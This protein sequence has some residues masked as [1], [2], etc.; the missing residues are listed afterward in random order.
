MRPGRALSSAAL[1]VAAFCG[2]VTSA[3]AYDGVH[4][5]TFTGGSIYGPGQMPESEMPGGYISNLKLDHML[6]GGME[7]FNNGPAEPNVPSEMELYG[8]NTGL[9]SDGT[10]FNEHAHGGVMPVGRGALRMVAVIAKIGPNGGH[11]KFR[12]DEQLNL[13]LL[14]DMALDP[15]FEQGLI[16]SKGLEITSGVLWVRQSLQT[17]AGTE[18]G[19]DFAAGLPSG[20][21]IF[22]RLGD[23]DEDGFLDG[24]LIG[25]GSAPIDYMFVPG[26]PLV[27]RRSFVT[28][29]PMSPRATGLLTLANVHNLSKVLA[30]YDNE[31]PTAT[32]YI[33]TELPTIAEEFATRAERAAARLSRVGAPEAAMAADIAEVL[34]SAVTSAQDPVQYKS[35]IAP[36]LDRLATAVPA[37]HAAFDKENS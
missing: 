15:G 8:R 35:S 3:S 28:D 30:V 26:A 17:K 14:A 6:N 31:V 37:L 7:W 4:L 21:P 25:I 24:E 27:Q 1:M 18:G 36:A 16:I 23:M 32:E 12:L 33:S 29:I 19:M 20:A 9:L 10:P 22:G 34:R 11:E 2:C 5:L 13:R